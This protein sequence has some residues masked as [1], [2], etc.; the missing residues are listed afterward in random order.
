MDC[1]IASR[2]RFGETVSGD[3]SF[4]QQTSDEVLLA[5]ID[6]LGHGRAAHVAA[7]A[8]VAALSPWRGRSLPTLISDCH[9]ALKD[10]RGAVM[11][12]AKFDAK[13]GTMNWLAVGNIEG[14]LLQYAPDG[15]VGRECLSIRCGIVGLHLPVLR[16]ETLL[17][18]ASDR[19]VLATDGIDS[20]LDGEI[21]LDLPP[22]QMAD[23]VLMRC[24]KLTD[25]ALVLVGGWT[26]GHD[27]A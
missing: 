8:A 15:T 5:V 21:T 16:S 10:T 19:I 25:D 18:H 9:S 20:G 14:R 26:G 4:V 23:R 1:G 3:L 17:I 24:G 7:R 27:G 6:G 11:A 12:L 2:R 22:Q 13:E